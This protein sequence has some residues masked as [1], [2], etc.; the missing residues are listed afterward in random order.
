MGI[1]PGEPV[2][3]RLQKATPQAGADRLNSK[4]FSADAVLAP[5]CASYQPMPK[6]MCS[7]W[8]V[9]MVELCPATSS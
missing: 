7:G 9:V 2:V 5:A 8:P 1:N 4:P 3:S 6:A